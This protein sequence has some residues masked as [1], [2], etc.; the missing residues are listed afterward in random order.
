MLENQARNVAIYIHIYYII[1][2]YIIYYYYFLL[3]LGS[4]FLKL[5]FF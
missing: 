4:Y 2:Y 5:Y 1:L 3:V